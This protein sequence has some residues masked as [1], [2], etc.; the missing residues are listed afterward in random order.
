MWLKLPDLAQARLRG[1]SGILQYGILNPGSGSK[2]QNGVSWHQGSGPGGGGRAPQ[3]SAGILVPRDTHS[4]TSGTNLNAAYTVTPFHLASGGFA[5]RPP[6]GQ[7]VNSNSI[8]QLGSWH[9]WQVMVVPRACYTLARD[10]G[11]VRKVPK[12]CQLAFLIPNSS[13]KHWY[14]AGTA[15]RPPPPPRSGGAELQLQLPL[16]RHQLFLYLL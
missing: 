1:G 13:S 11:K 7:V 9:S 14:P 5:P 12:L 4:H 6:C 10:S 16:S 15:D 2:W 3:A 8:N